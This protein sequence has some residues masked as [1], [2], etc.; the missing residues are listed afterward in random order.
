M[1]SYN[2]ET[3]SPQVINR[4]FWNKLEDGRIKEAADEGSG[5]IRTRMREDSFQRRIIVPKQI[6]ETE[7]DR[8]E[9][10]DFPKVV[11]DKEP[12]SVASFLP[13]MGTAKQKL[14]TGKRY[15]AYFGKVESQRNTM[16]KFQLLTYRYDV[17][18]VLSDNCVKDMAAEE[19]RVFLKTI[20]DY[21]TTPLVGVTADYEVDLTAADHGISNRGIKKLLQK[22]DS[23][24][25]PVGKLL[26]AKSTFREI[27]EYESFN[28][29]EAVMQRIFEQGVDTETVI[30]G[31]P[32]V[33]TVKESLFTKVGGVVQHCYLFTTEEFFGKSFLLQDATL[34]LE[35]RADMLEFWAYEAIA[36][37]I[38]SF[39]GAIRG[40][41]A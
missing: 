27:L 24:E 17:R 16:S 34:Y 4:A 10:N 40:V 13:F 14:F 19:D 1:N 25:L 38:G 31:V 5:F 36:T 11:I 6:D 35:K 39:N 8:D 20:N 37:G 33:V 18:K 2:V 41:L 32:V 21:I 15:A 26:L 30:F 9:D 3:L 23:K 29:S 7:I 28:V 12:D 22:M